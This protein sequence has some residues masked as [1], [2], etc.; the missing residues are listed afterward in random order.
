MYSKHIS[1]ISEVDENKPK[2]EGFKHFGQG[3]QTHEEIFEE[4][5]SQYME[6][7]H[8]ETIYEEAETFDNKPSTVRNNTKKLDYIHNDDKEVPETFTNDDNKSCK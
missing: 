4:A 1:P 5:S 8:R 6:S 3:Q 7:E 2:K